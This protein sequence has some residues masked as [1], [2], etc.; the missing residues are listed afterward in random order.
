MTTSY[1]YGK[2]FSNKLANLVS[3]PG[4]VGSP[5]ELVAAAK[6]RGSL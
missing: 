5:S 1:V 2:G 3:K 6:K 4:C